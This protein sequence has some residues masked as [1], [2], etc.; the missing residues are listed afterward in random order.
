MAELPRRHRDLAPRPDAGAVADRPILPGLGSLET[1]IVALG[2]SDDPGDVFFQS[3]VEEVLKETKLAYALAI[4]S[5]W[6]R[7]FAADL[8]EHTREPLSEAL[9][10]IGAVL[11]A[12]NAG[13][14]TADAVAAADAAL[15][16][17]LSRLDDSRDSS[18]SSLS[19]AASAAISARRIVAIM[20]QRAGEK[21]DDA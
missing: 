19:T 6:E 11:I 1:K 18:P 3:D 13:D 16:T 15:Q 8:P 2:E 4:Q 21:N 5:I 12:R 7:Q 10:A 14:D 9:R 17:A 20:A